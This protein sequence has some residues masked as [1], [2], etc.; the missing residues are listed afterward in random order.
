MH[1]HQQIAKKLQNRKNAP[2][3]TFKFKTKLTKRVYN[4]IQ[5]I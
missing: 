1:E 2:K 3:R 5:K 4:N